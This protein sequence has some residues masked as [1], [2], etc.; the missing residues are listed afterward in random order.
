MKTNQRSISSDSPIKTFEVSSLVNKLIFWSGS[1][2]A[3]STLKIVEFH[4][5]AMGKVLTY[6]C[7]KYFT[8][9]TRKDGPIKVNPFQPILFNIC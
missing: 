1:L 5:D 7:S 3:K 9:K 2:N 4:V 8:A 6:T